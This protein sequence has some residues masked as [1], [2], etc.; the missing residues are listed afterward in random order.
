M[1]LVN[2]AVYVPLQLLMVV[3][4]QQSVIHQQDNIKSTAINLHLRNTSRSIRL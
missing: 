4:L 3:L 1:S 2:I